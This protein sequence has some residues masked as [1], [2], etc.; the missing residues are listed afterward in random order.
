MAQQHPIATTR[1]RA[2]RREET[3]AEHRLWQA[4]RSRRLGGFK[5][6]R[7]LTIGPF[8]ADFACREHRLIVEVDGATHGSDEEVAYDQRRTAYLESQGYRVLRFW[9][10]DI[11]TAL[12][13]VCDAILLA[14][15][16]QK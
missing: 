1:A 7:Q 8:I 6:V 4:L 3:E 2:F 14:L 5:F 15:P 13:A 10:Q 16:V 11:Y 12:N 9:N